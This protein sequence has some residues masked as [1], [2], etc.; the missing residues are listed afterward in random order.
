MMPS[1]TSSGNRF[2]GGT[3]RRAKIDANQPEV[4]KAFRRCGFT[5]VCTHTVGNGFPD[6]V[7]ARHGW[8]AL[9]EIKD[10][11]KCKSARKLTPDEEKF[12]REWPGEIHIIESPDDV[13]RLYQTLV[14]DG[15]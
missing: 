14:L 2:G 5:V 13:V 15:H 3:L 10:G 4:V 6:L 7:V 1:N 12:H 8:T 11:S 9:I